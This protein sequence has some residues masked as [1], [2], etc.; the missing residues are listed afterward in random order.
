[1]NAGARHPQRPVCARARRPGEARPRH[2]GQATVEF[3]LVF[4]L[5]LVSLLAIID[6][7]IWTIETDAVDASVERGIGVAMS[8]L[9][10]AVSPTP[11]LTD[12]YSSVLPLLRAPLLG[13]SL[14]DWYAPDLDG[15]RTQVGPTRCPS[16]D[17]VADYFQSRGSGLQGVGH[18]VVCAVEDG[19]G[20]VIVAVTGFAVSFVPPG[21]GPFNWRG[22][23]LPISE[24]ASV[25]VGTYSP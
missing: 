5:F 20:H 24:S 23:G 22:W 9:G 4:G 13:T 12:V 25:N 18:L 15:L 7:W 11:A 6:A 10:S 17:E 8:A 14:E 21:L 2:R 3:S 16:A 19:A 1:V